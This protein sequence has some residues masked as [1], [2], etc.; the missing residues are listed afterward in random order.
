MREIC[1]T[2]KYNAR[3]FDGHCNC[4]FCCGNESSD[5]YSMPTFY[6]DFCEDWEESEE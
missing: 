4:E 3:T 6:D 2:C 5:N 1:G